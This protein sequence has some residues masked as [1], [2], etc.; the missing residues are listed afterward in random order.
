MPLNSIRTLLG[1]P[2]ATNIADDIVVYGRTT[3]KHDS[4]LV[5]LLERLQVEHQTSLVKNLQVDKL[6]KTEMHDI[7]K[8]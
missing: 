4:N 3:E 1:R 2:G 6:I 5:I 8:T 7:K